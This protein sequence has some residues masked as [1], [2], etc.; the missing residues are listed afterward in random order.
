MRRDED[1]TVRKVLRTDIPG[2]GKR[3]RR[4]IRWKEA[5]QQYLE[6][7]RIESE[8]GDGHGDTE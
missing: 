8:R 2:K 7:Y 5:I 3:G 1:H 6:K 4:K